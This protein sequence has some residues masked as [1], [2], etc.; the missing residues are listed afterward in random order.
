MCELLD[1]FDRNVGFVASEPTVSS[2]LARIDEAVPDLR[3][4][5]IHRLV[6]RTLLTSA[7]RHEQS[8]SGPNPLVSFGFSR[9]NSSMHFLGAVIRGSHAAHHS[10]SIRTQ[11]HT[12]R[13]APNACSAWNQL[14]KTFRATQDGRF[15]AY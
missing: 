11:C 5:S 1:R 6:I 3:I 14:N 2:S 10:K 15:S 12:P 13:R 9:Q 7:L 8:S 4:S